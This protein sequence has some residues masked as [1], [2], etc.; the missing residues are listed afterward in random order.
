MAHISEAISLIILLYLLLANVAL[1]DQYGAIRFD[2]N[3]NFS[4]EV[5]GAPTVRGSLFLWYG[6]WKYATPSGVESIGQ[7]SWRG[8]MPEPGV[9]DGYISYTQTVKSTPDGGADVALHFRKNGDIH[10]RRGIF[11]LI[12]FQTPEMS[13]RVISFTHGPPS[14]VLDDYKVA[15]RGFNVNLSDSAALEFSLD[16]AGLFE[17]RGGESSAYMNVRLSADA[18]AK[19]NIHLRFKPGFES[20]QSWQPEPQRSHLSINDVKS[21]MD[22]VPRFH[23]F[24]FTVDLSATYDNPFD[25]DDIALDATFITPSGGKMKLPGFFYQGFKAEYEDDLEL[26]SL[27]GEPTWKVRFAP[28]EIGSYSATVSV[29]DRSGTVI[30]E[31]K[32]FECVESD[33]RGF[34]R[35]SEPPEP[36]APR[37]FEFDNGD[38]LF[39][40]GHNMPTY[41]ARVEEYFSK[42]E[43]GGENYNRFWMYRTALG[44]EWGQPVG[45]YRLVEA[46]NMDRAIEAAARHGIYLML[47]FDTHQDFREVWEHNPYSEKQGGPCSKALDFFTNEDARA[48][49][50]KRL[51]YITARWTAYPHVLAWEFMN[52][53]E[54]WPGTQENRAAVTD[55]NV[56]MGRFLRELD[57]YKRPISNSLWTTEGW[58]ELWNLPEMDFVQSHFYANSPKDMAQMVAS[59]GA[60]KRADYPNKLHVFAEYGI[61][62]G[63]GTRQNDPSG[64]HL[65]NGNWAGFMSGAASVPASWWHESYIDPEGLYRVYRGL[66]NFVADEDDLAKTA[67]KPLEVSSISYIQPPEQLTYTDLRF[68]AGANN[69]KKPEET[70][71]TIREDGTVENGEHLP[72]LLHGYAHNELRVPLTFRLDFPIAG[73]FILHIGRV[74]DNGLLK[75]YL[76]GEE[77][78]VVDLPTGEGLGVSS[79]YI[80]RWKRWETTYNKDATVNVPAGKHEVQIQNDGQDWITIDCFRLTNYRTNAAPNLRILGMQTSEKALIWAQNRAYTWFNVRD[81]ASIPPVGPTKL[82]LFGFID[83][84]YNVELWDTVEGTVVERKSSTA[85]EGKLIIHLPEVKHDIAVKIEN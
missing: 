21:S 78:S 84:K 75:F 27:D 25:P 1:C 23:P 47:C 17:R 34:L 80:D 77:I 56:E 85:A 66:A 74:G 58:P 50:K 19:V 73:E 79:I 9:T 64:V 22:R 61:M 13:E 5:H 65:H 33:S 39:L 3:G 24:E 82:T 52:E 26:L 44:L 36:G 46:R 37:Y 20:V 69:W 48:L 83:G 68:T 72:G 29:Q 76:D 62:A 71:F 49:Y 14:S 59:I 6:D 38:P 35:I 4:I 63:G 81:G 30:S 10:L 2:E 12:Q 41:S 54:G 15:A 53:L 31:E 8:T 7:N 40:I 18:D 67:W 42:M 11:L 43:A 32:R 28:T 16:R 51:R 45:T 70:V 57:P 60:Q 55:W